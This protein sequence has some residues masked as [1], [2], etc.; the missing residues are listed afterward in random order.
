[1]SFHRYMAGALP[2]PPFAVQVARA[3]VLLGVW[4]GLTSPS[5]SWSWR[6]GFSALAIASCIGLGSR[7]WAWWTNMATNLLSILLWLGLI[8]WSLIES[9]QIDGV[10][11]GMVFVAFVMIGV[12]MLTLTGIGL[13]LLVTAPVPQYYLRT[14]RR[15][16]PT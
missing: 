10:D 9:S 8:I 7:S 6:S 3:F 12:P 14:I 16:A 11:G 1:M 4:P 15:R 5:S 13:G 2:S